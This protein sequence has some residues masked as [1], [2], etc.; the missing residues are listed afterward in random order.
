MCIYF[1]VVAFYRGSCSDPTHQTAY[2]ATR[3]FFL[4]ED[5][6]NKELWQGKVRGSSASLV[7]ASDTRGMQD[8]CD[9]IL[10]QQNNSPSDCTHVPPVVHTGVI[11]LAAHGVTEQNAAPSS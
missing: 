5:L 11:S 8:R 10:G 9:I 1:M 7:L 3:G 4:Q 6:T 2:G